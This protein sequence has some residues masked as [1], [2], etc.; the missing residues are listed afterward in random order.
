MWNTQIFAPDR[1]R[2]S[3]TT[4]T[5]CTMNGFATGDVI[6]LNDGKI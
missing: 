5:S 2:E 4:I 3:L 1:E 6:F